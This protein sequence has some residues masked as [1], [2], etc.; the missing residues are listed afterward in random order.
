[1]TSN[2]RDV[3]QILQRVQLKNIE[4]TYCILQMKSLHEYD[5]Y[6]LAP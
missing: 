1:M 5:N 2:T 6:H 4:V 3:I